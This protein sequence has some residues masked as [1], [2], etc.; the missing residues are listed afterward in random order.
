[1]TTYKRIR[2]CETNDFYPLA[3]PMEYAEVLS[4]RGCKANDETRTQ[5]MSF[6]GISQTYVDLVIA[7]IG[8]IERR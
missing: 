4:V 7:Y 6:A 8:M 5:I 3:P 1:M 2:Q